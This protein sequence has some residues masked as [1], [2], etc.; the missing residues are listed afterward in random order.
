MGPKN[1]KYIL[2][3]FIKQNNQDDFVVD[4]AGEIAILTKSSNVRYFYGTDASVYTFSTYETLN[5]VKEYL[6]IIL[7]EDGA[8][9]FLL[10]YETDNMSF[11]LPKDVA[12]HL[13]GELNTDKK[14][15]F[16]FTERKLTDF[17]LMSDEAFEDMLSYLSDGDEDD[18]EISKLIKRTKEVKVNDL[19]SEEIFNEILDKINDKGMPSLNEKELSLLKKY[20]KQLN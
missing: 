16:K 14:S 9:Y 5:E 19:V 8:V 3:L 6:D 7:S 1:F 10:P 4:I 13:F 11:G 18:D 17:P 15:D 12:S 2:F 20:S